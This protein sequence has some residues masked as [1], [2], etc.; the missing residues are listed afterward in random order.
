M[1]MK[2]I[3]GM[4]VGGLVSTGIIMLCNEEFTKNN[5]TKKMIKK[6]KQFLRK[7]M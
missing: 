7:M 3:K 4:M 6:G 5:N 1:S 2:F